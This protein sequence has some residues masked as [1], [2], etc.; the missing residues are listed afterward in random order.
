MVRSELVAIVAAES[1]NMSKA[2]VE[3][4]VDVLFD[5]I[6]GALENG[7]RVE[8]RGFG[9][10]AGRRRKPRSAVNPRTGTSVS[11]PSKV[12]PTFKAGKVL[13]AKVNAAKA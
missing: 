1:P 7:D 2:D 3:R 10:F 11:V 4:V 13:R 8:I 12:F 6:I 9:V 5:T